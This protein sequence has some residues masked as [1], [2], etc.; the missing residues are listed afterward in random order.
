[1]V[2]ETRKTKSKCWQGY[3]PSDGSRGASFLVY[4]SFWCL[5]MSLA[6]GSV[7]PISVSIFTWPSSHLSFSASYMG[8]ITGFRAHLSTLKSYFNSYLKYFCK[9]LIPKLGH[10][11]SVMGI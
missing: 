7:T 4:S 5:L 10:I 2:L 9:G 11:Q 8:T 6:C 1:M 3:T